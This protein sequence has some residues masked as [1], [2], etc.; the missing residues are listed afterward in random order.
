MI[1]CA[2][3]L[4]VSKDRYCRLTIGIWP[5]SDAITSRAA[6]TCEGSVT[7]CR[8]SVMVVQVKSRSLGGIPTEW[9]LVSKAEHTVLQD[10]AAEGRCSRG[11]EEG[12]T[13]KFRAGGSEYKDS[14]RERSRV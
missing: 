1:S 12:T 2:D 9:L 4:S 6:W 3:A 14:G 10:T 7:K 5:E 13:V 8:V 11:E